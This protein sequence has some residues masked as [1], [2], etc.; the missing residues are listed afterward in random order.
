MSLLRQVSND[1]CKWA[2]GGQLF[3][4]ILL[5]SLPRM[6]APKSLIRGTNRCARA[7]M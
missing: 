2:S 1:V 4:E 3:F 6:A 5:T 7:P